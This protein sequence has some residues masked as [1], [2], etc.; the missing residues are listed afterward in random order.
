VP[1]EA[2]FSQC[3]LGDAQEM[4]GGEAGVTS[5]D[6]SLAFPSA[7]TFFYV[8][9]RMCE[10]LTD[11]C[12][13]SAFMHKLRVEVLPDPYIRPGHS[14]QVAVT[15]LAVDLSLFEGAVGVDLEGSLGGLSEAEEAAVKAFASDAA[16]DVEAAVRE[17]TDTQAT[18]TCLYRLADAFRLNLLTLT[19]EC[20]APRRL[21]EGRRAQD[22]SGLGV[23][24][25]F[26]KPVDEVSID[27]VVIRSGS[28]AVRAEATT[29]LARPAASDND[30]PEF[31]NNIKP[32]PPDDA[33][34]NSG[35]VAVTAGG[36]LMQ[37]IF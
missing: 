2:A 28:V 34:V 5:L 25:I 9:A 35:L 23:V 31:H 7:G 36:M 32:A 20:V 16:G 1:D 27:E 24:M 37:R 6:V 26:K 19:D 8:C 30:L 11:W 17:S 15:T 13:C 33:I 14:G 22:E 18:V 10:P 3:L 12:H 21:R 4:G 29:V